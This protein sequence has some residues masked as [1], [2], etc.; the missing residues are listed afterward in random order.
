MT[1]KTCILFLILF[2]S[3]YFIF[4]D[5]IAERERELSEVQN[6]IE[7]Q[8]RR[9][10]ETEERRRTAERTKQQTQQQLN[11]QQRRLQELISTGQNLRSSHDHSR[12]LLFQTE[13]R[14]SSL[15]YLTN[16]TMLHLLLAD[17][18]HQ[19][20]RQSDNDTYLL[21]LLLQNLIVENQ[22]LD[23]ERITLASETE[24]RARAVNE[25]VS[26]TTTERTRI[27][28]ISSNLRDIDTE[29]QN[30]ERQRE[31]FL[32]QVEEL[33]NA[34]V[35][36]QN[37]I[38]LLKEE[39]QRYQHTFI[40]TSGVE[41]PA[42]GRILTHFGPRRHERYNIS[43]HSNGV[44]ISLPENSQVRALS[45]GEVVFADWF[46]ANGRM[47]II[48]HKNGFH[49]VYS[50]LNNFLIRHGDIVTKGQ[51]IAESGKATI[52]S[53]PSLHFEIRRNGVAVNPLDYVRIE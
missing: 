7:E 11:V 30:I 16:E 50:Y 23:I 3:I 53:V 4:A 22:I 10:I 31:E 46:T 1:L 28:T 17:Q 35:A 29:I 37:L 15:Q 24:A 20:L 43:I 48:N 18:A 25:I 52:T 51:V 27:D 2:F 12:N 34:S 14:L 40:F 32:K 5:D 13:G 26:Q 47:I 9:A 42:R 6:R 44:D 19:K 45:D 38:N 39:A 33:Q 36:L 21:S 49:S 8:R 41:A